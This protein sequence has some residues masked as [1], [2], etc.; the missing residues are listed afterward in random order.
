M[1][2][3]KP[4]PLEAFRADAYGNARGDFDTCL[5]A[6]NAQADAAALVCR[7]LDG[8]A[9]ETHNE[10]HAQVIAAAHAALCS[11]V[12]KMDAALDVLADCEV[13]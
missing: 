11:I 3:S 5:A 8:M 4:D 2:T 13:A 9:N 10:E 12:V 6:L 7:A 1:N